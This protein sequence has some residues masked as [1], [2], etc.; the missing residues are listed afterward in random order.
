MTSQSKNNKKKTENFSKTFGRYFPTKTHEIFDKNPYSVFFNKIMIFSL[1][2]EF[3]GYFPTKT[4]DIFTDIFQQ[5]LMRFSLKILGGY[6]MT[7]TSE[8]FH[9]VLRSDHK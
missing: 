2:K 1:K 8:I 7:K 5:N 3:G 6:L 9:I 4:H